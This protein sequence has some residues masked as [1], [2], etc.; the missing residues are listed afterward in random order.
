MKIRLSCLE[1]LA[2]ERS[3]AVPVAHP[4]SIMIPSGAHGCS[5]MLPTLP[6]AP[7]LLPAQECSFVLCFISCSASAVRPL[8][9]LPRPWIQLC[10]PRLRHGRFASRAH[11]NHCVR[12]DHL[13]MFPLAALADG[14][15]TI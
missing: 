11:M 15:P 1:R 7:R 14:A 13:R 9:L 10:A 2:L 6:R 3:D 5:F 12:G 8:R 4:F